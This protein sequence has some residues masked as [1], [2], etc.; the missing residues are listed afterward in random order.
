MSR[1]K[2]SVDSPFIK[3]WATRIGQLILNFT[4]LEFESYF[5]LVQMSEQ[6]NRIAEF[7]KLLFSKRVKKILEY[8]ESLAFNDNWKLDSIAA[9]QNALEQSKLRN[10]IAHNP[11]M[12]AWN[13]QSEEGEPDFIGIA[14]MKSGNR[15]ESADGPLLSKAEIDSAINQI[16][17]LVSNLESLRVSWCSL[18]DERRDINLP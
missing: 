6:P 10:R 3:P 12:F 7:T 13:D 18:R 17:S 1:I 16:N 11:L 9:W 5:W 4:G 2:Y 15:P 8:V 14:D